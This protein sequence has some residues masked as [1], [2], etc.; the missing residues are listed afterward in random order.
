M[1]FAIH[2]LLKSIKSKCEKNV[3]TYFDGNR[4]KMDS[5]NQLFNDI[6]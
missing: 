3:F 5:N 4:M 6:I 1:K 2:K